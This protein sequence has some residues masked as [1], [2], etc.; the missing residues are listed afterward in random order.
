MVDSK[1][2]R[3]DSGVQAILM[4]RILETV[5]LLIKRLCPL[6]IISASK[7]PAVFIFSFNNK[8]TVFR[9][10]NVVYLRRPRG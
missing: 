9:N 7:Y 8:Y 5:F 3:K 6:F 10:Y 2:L 1:K 4:Q